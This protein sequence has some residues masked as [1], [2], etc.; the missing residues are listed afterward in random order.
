MATKLHRLCLHTGMTISLA[1]PWVT[2]H[3]TETVN[4]Q[5]RSAAYTHCLEQTAQTTADMHDCIRI[6]QAQ[7]TQSLQ[8]AYARQLKHAHSSHQT[9]ALHRSQ[10]HWQ[11][12]RDSHCALFKNPQGGSANSMAVGTC[13]VRL[14]GQR[15]EE[16]EQLDRME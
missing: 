6:K 7:Q 9:Q 2:S 13:Q 15:L 16:L 5:A 14:T 1:T 4:A 12:Y 3:A 8:T 10:T 11:R